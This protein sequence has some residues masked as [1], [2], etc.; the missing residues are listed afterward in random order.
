[1]AAGAAEIDE[2]QAIAALDGT[3]GASPK[4]RRYFHE[5]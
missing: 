4:R 3:S 1:M 2:E 5:T